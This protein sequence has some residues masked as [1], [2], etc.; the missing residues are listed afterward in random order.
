MARLE[1]RGELAR[2]KALYVTTYYDNPS[3][4]TVRPSVAAASW[5]LPSAG[6]ANKIYIIE[7]AA[8]RELR[9]Y[10]DDVPSLRSS[11][12]AATR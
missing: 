10:G 11:T 5:R 6:R 7:D 2:V 1:A 4:V 3:G 9:Y 12:P 8:Y